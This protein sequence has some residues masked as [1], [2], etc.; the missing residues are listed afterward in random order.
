MK[1]KT[2][3]KAVGIWLRVSTEDQ[4]RGESPEHHERR[5]RSYA[6]AKDWHV[7]TV[8]RLD[9]VSGKTVKEHPEAKRM[10]KDVS[11]GRITGLVFSKLARLARNTKELLEFADTFRDHGADLISLAES[12]DT[13]TP[14][15]RLFFTMIAAMATW[16]REEIASR[17]AASVPVRAQMGK[18]TGGSASFGYKWVD[19][20]LVP[21]PAE[22]SV[23]K[24]LYELFREH[25]R[26]KT[27]AR[28][29]NEMGHRTRGGGKFSDTTV[30]R[31][32]RDP[33]AKGLRRANYT[34]ST[35]ANGAWVM[36]PES[37]W[38]WSEVE[39]IVPE[40]LW[41]ECIA[42]LDEN[43]ASARPKTRRT[44]HLFAGYTFCHC[45]TKMYVPSD[46]PK[47]ICQKCRN[48]IPIDDLERIFHGELKE[49]IFSPS[50]IAAHLESATGKIGEK[51]EALAH[52]EGEHRKVQGQIDKLLELYQAGAIDKQGFGIRYYPLSEQL[53]QLA[54]QIPVAQADLDALKILQLSQEEVFSGA[55]D[56]ASAWPSLSQEDRRQIVETIT[57]RI[58]VSKDE[59]TID[60][61]GLPT[62]EGPGGGDDEPPPGSPSSP[63]GSK[64]A[65]NQHGFIAATIWKRAG[66]SECRAAR[67]IVMCPVSSGSRSTSSTCRL[68]SGSSSR[69]RTPRCAS[70]ISPGRGTDPP[71]TSAIPDAVWCGARNGRR[72]KRRASNPPAPI[73]SIAATSTA[74]S[75]DSGGIS[76][77]NRAASM[78]LPAPGGPIISSE[79]PPAAAISIA[80]FARCWPR[81][82]AMSGPGS[83]ATSPR[84]DGSLSFSS[85]P[86]SAEA[87]A[88]RCLAA[89]TRADGA[90]IASS[91][92]AAGSS[93]RR[94]AC[95]HRS[96]AGS[97]PRTGRSSPDSESSPST[98]SPARF[99]GGTCDEALRMPSAIARSKRPPSFGRSAG[100]RLQVMR[101]FGNS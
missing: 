46:S 73:D 95:A 92:L 8:Y 84:G 26:K 45:G 44:V 17:V 14:A 75:V 19:K 89:I 52:L 58:T 64:K 79:C 71:P 42:I 70:V 22:A 15:G 97:A 32:L 51:A 13:S 72:P 87:T 61:I 68:N 88:A 21:E 30:E 43:R 94:P 82:S 16:E 63:N 59:V 48:K 49:L 35:E 62:L 83:G 18:P 66:K 40:A 9:A 29:L 53:A 86:C 96:A 78:L 50:R 25:K 27:V 101:R 5:A 33:T 41:S 1:P 10:L 38:V 99:T 28:L 69:K 76:P 7:V 80:R 31:L 34:R 93:N 23:R 67:E 54:D 6:E 91:A 65:T 90:S 56:L 98:S 2:Q 3:S 60:L 57:E 39:A 100:A 81:T 11:E 85:V 4:V 47:Y 12:I 74:S 77:G 36:K 20:K 55:R 37:E 24:L